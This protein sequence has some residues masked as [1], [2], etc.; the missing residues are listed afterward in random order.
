MRF[1]CS[2][3]TVPNPESGGTLSVF[4]QRCHEDAPPDSLFPLGLT[5]APL[6]DDNAHRG[7]TIR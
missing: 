4:G 3:Q 7:D 6:V 2:G 1:L 5:N